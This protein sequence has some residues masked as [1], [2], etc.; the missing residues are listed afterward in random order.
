MKK[1]FLH[2]LMFGFV[3]LCSTSAFSVALISNK[4]PFKNTNI[5][6][7]KPEFSSKSK[8]S[9]TLDLID[10]IDFDNDEIQ[11]SAYQSDA[12]VFFDFSKST[13]FHF[14]FPNILV[15][16]KAYQLC[17]LS[18]IPRF[19]FLTI[20]AFRIWFAKKSFRQNLVLIF[21]FY[22]FLIL[23]LPNHEKM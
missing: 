13:V 16:T 12:D 5:C 21:N 17:V 10:T 9:V 22:S 14:S 11:K 3:A 4:A 6:I 8:A 2:Y 19:S 18:R 7:S 20:G 15:H 1:Y 23:I